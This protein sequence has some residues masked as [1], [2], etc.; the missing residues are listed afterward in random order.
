MT[1]LAFNSQK[2]SVTNGEF[3]LK[4]LHP[5][6]K[7]SKKHPES[8]VKA[9]IAAIKQFGFTQPII[10]DENRTILAGHGRYEAA[11]KLGLEK[12]PTRQVIGLTEQEKKAYVIA[13]NKISEQSEWDQDKL[14]DELSS[15]SNLDDFD[16]EIANLLDQDTFSIYKIEQKPISDLKPHPK[17]YKNHPADQVE[18]LKKSISDNG[19]YRNVITA[20]DGTILA[21]HG[22]VKA[23]TELGL[24]SVPVVR[25]QISSSSIQ[26]TKL[27]TADNEVS[28]LGEV[29][30]R[31]LSNILKEIMEK[32]DLLGTGYD[33]QMLANLLF[34]TRPASEIKDT[35]HAKEWVGMPEYERDTGEPKKLIISFE[36]Y[37]DKKQFCELINLP[38]AEKEKESTWFPFK[39]RTDMQSI[40]FEEEE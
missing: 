5:Y 17:N 18:H 27:L 31:A 6:P 33:D 13:D 29:D 20:K 19:I 14:F 8:Q 23:A 36:S 3:D 39:E 9:L 38:F 35:D 1:Q 25:L 15:L 40:A 4:E 11:T 16:L 32:D 24:T 22:V 37:D 10:I 34:V 12:A 30:D 21:G 28:H 26:A 7:N 2:V